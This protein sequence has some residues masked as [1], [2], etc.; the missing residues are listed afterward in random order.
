MARSKQ[1][2]RDEE[3]SMQIINL[4]IQ[5]TKLNVEKSTLIFNKGILIYFSFLFVGI[6]GV[7]QGYVQQATLNLLIILGMLAMIVGAI[8]YLFTSKREE[9][10]LNELLDVL[11]KKRGLSPLI[12][13]VLLIAFAVALGAVVMNWGQAQLQTG[14]CAKV[15]IDFEIINSEPQICKNAEGLTIFLT[16]RGKVVVDQFKVVAIGSSNQE[17]VDIAQ[18]LGVADTRQISA[19]LKEV[20]FVR[21]AKV[22]PGIENTNGE[23]EFCVD[24]EIK[25]LQVPTCS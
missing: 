18:S 14:S 6:I 11:R 19:P 8:P 15:E 17:S 1:S 7:M 22:V 2:A 16:N 5:K 4:E 13:T 20:S 25:V 24:Q 9:K 3:L 23:V 12:A 21:L 10:K